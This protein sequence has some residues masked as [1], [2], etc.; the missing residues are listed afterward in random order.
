[1]TFDTAWGLLILF[2]KKG[3]EATIKHYNSDLTILIRFPA[4]ALWTDEDY[5]YIQL[6]DPQN[7]LVLGESWGLD[8]NESNFL[9]KLV[10]VLEETQME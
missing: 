6:G 2:T 7:E 9:R 10:S 1:M 4:L 5:S 3:V 8:H